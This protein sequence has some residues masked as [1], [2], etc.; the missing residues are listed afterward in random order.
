MA[1]IRSYPSPWSRKT[2]GSKLGTHQDPF[3]GLM[4]IRLHK[5]PRYIF[6]TVPTVSSVG[7]RI[8]WSLMAGN[9]WMCGWWFCPCLRTSQYRQESS[10]GREVGQDQGHVPLSLLHQIPAHVSEVPGMLK[11]RSEVRTK[12]FIK[13]V[14]WDVF[15]ILFIILLA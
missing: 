12:I 3:Q 4:E 9:A 8:G 10:V 2:K 11:E 14:E 13:I 15:Y 5:L 7:A 6:L 1:L